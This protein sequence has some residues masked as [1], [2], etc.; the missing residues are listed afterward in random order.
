VGRL[1]RGDCVSVHFYAGE[2]VSASDKNFDQTLT[3]EVISYD[4]HGYYL[5]VPHYMR[6]KH[7]ILVE[8]TNYRHL[9]VDEKYLGEEV[10][11]VMEESVYRVEYI[12]DGMACHHC[13]EFIEWAA[14]NRDDGTFFCWACRENPYR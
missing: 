4:N 5:F 6:L 8:T 3:L 1:K 10:L 2:V 13:K 9:V 12:L 14:P 11:Y 7:T